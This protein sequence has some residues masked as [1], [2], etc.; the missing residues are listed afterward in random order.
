MKKQSMKP[1]DLSSGWEQVVNPVTAKNRE[2]VGAKVRRWLLALVVLMA[3]VL[4]SLVLWVANMMP[5]SASI[6]AAGVCSCM[7]C[8]V[9]G[10]LFEVVN[11]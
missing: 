6:V 2:Q 9:A 7:G 3:A 8:F 5:M 4:L 11:R 1:L 10:R